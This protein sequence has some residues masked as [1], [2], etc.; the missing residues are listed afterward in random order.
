MAFSHHLG[1]VSTLKTEQCRLLNY[2]PQATPSIF[3]LRSSPRL[4]STGQLHA[5]L[6]FHL[7]PINDVVFVVPYSI[8]MRDLILGGVSRLD[9]FSVYL[10]RT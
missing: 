8:W 1:A 3:M 4:I 9:A 5:L 7:R 2:H 6:H 10:V